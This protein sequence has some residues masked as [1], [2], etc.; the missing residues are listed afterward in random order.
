MVPHPESQD[1]VAGIQGELRVAH[2]IAPVVVAEERLRPVRDPLD[3][4]P[5][6]PGREGAEDVLRVDRVLAPEP[7][8]DIV[9]E[10]PEPTFL[11]AED[12]GE[13]SPDAVRHL[14]RDVQGPAARLEFGDHPAGLQGAE[15][16]AVVDDPPPHDPVGGRE[17]GFGRLRVADLPSERDVVGD[18]VPDRR[19]PGRLVA[20]GDG[21]EGFVVDL[22][23][24]ARVEGLPAGLGDDEGDALPDEADP[25]GGK[26]GLVPRAKPIALADSGPVGLRGAGHAG[27]LRDPGRGEL[28]SR[29]HRPHPRRRPRRAGVDAGDPG[30]REGRPQNHRV[31]GAGGRPVVDEAPLAPQQPRVLAAQHRLA[32][33]E[34]FHGPG[35]SLRHRGCEMK[36]AGQPPSKRRRTRRRASTPAAWRR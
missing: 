19:P 34:S 6:V 30:V 27:D 11:D 15:L 2:Q 4:A 8:A 14:G 17:R 18:I 20:G 29:V 26:G 13:L 22:D 28:G 7:S 24:L 23:P 33:P 1:A 3:R 16:G 9:D 21:G 32:H 35:S 36:V 12:L 10:H 5:E 25:V 31:Q